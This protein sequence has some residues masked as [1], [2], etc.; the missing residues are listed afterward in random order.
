MLLIQYFLSILKKHKIRFIACI[1][2][3][4]IGF[5]AVF[6]ISAYTN[7]MDKT[8]NDVFFLE[9]QSCMILERGSSIIKLIPTESEI[10]ENVIDDIK[11][12]SGVI[13]AF[14]LIFK[15]AVSEIDTSKK[16]SEKKMGSEKSSLLD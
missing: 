10:P 1:L 15:S 5:G 11:N 14:P 4:G 7:I 16:K 9:D 6:A 13:S 3:L 2:G 12:Q 8:I